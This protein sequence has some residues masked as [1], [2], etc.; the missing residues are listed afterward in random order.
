MTRMVP[1][2]VSLSA[3]THLRASHCA[4]GYISFVAE[5]A[6][7][8]SELLTHLDGLQQ[9]E[10]ATFWHRNLLKVGDNKVVSPREHLDAADL[11][12]VLL[13]AS[14]LSS[15]VGRQEL[16][17]ALERQ[18]AGKAWVVP[19]LARPVLL[20]GMTL[21][22]LKIVPREA[23]TSYGDRHDAWVEVCEEL[24]RC[25]PLNWEPVQ[26]G[27]AGALSAS[28]PTGTRRRRRWEL[29]L[30][31]GLGGMFLQGLGWIGWLGPQHALMKREVLALDVHE[32]Q[33]S[34]DPTLEFGERPFRLPTERGPMYEIIPSRSWERVEFKDTLESTPED[35]AVF[36][37]E[38]GEHA[39]IKP[40]KAAGARG[41]G[42]V[43]TTVLFD[44]RRPDAPVAVM[45]YTRAQFRSWD[46][47]SVPI[48]ESAWELVTSIEMVFVL[49]V[50]S[51]LSGDLPHVQ[52]LQCRERS[53]SRPKEARSYL[54]V[55]S[56]RS[57]SYAPLSSILVGWKQEAVIAPSGMTLR[58]LYR[59]KKDTRLRVPASKNREK[60]NEWDVVKKNARTTV[61]CVDLSQDRP[62]KGRVEVKVSISTPGKVTGV[63]IGGAFSNT[64]FGLCLQNVISRW[65]FPRKPTP[66]EAEFPLLF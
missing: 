55:A 51:G 58:D 60:G 37:A 35:F 34:R 2:T 14:Y 3:P 56:L 50:A 20:Q 12:V 9:R 54:G 64:S 63:T 57:L 27:G 5:D 10:Q 49:P 16:A 36:A 66:Y 21:E 45:R 19:V 65:K 48:S 39:I 42:W 15:D 38:L 11:V 4:C 61:P 47:G 28:A 30:I 23:V 43:T 40:T 1:D 41:G 31:V 53:L 62:F 52:A 22:D 17:R 33:G 8:L 26:R 6:D 59:D 25:K 18:R 32:R 13:S 24:L 7:L 44:R 46:S 29:L